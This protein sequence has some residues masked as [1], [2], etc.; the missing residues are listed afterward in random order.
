MQGVTF[1][2]AFIELE[3]I[4]QQLESGELALEETIALYER[5]QALARYC[6]E[7]LDQAELRVVQLADEALGS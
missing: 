7:R 5:G 6:Q 1:E 2:T 4:V 3:Q